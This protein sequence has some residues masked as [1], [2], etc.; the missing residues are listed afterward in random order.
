[1]WPKMKTRSKSFSFVTTN[2]FLIKRQHFE[3]ELFS[4]DSL[5]SAIFMFNRSQKTIIAP[6][7]VAMNSWLKMKLAKEGYRTTMM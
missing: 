1:M 6:M 4:L 5:R 3:S 7:K 2:L